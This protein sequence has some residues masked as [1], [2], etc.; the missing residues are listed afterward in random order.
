MLCDAFAMVAHRR[1][2]AVKHGVFAQ[3]GHFA[4]VAM[5]GGRLHRW[6]AVQYP[7]N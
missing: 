6:F 2:G 1:V 7:H 4:M 3:N 5:P